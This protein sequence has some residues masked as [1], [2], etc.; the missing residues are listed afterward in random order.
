MAA[1]IADFDLACAAAAL[2]V[3]PVKACAA[4]PVQALVLDARGAAAGD[5][6]WAIVNADG[7]VT[8]QGEFPR[9]ALVHPRVA[10]AGLLLAS[11]GAGEVAT[12]A[13]LADCEVK[14]WSD[15]KARHETFEAADAGDAVAAWLARVVG[16]PARLVRLGEA[17]IAREGNNALH[18]VFAPSVRAVDAQLAAAGRPGADPRRYRPNIVLSGLAGEDGVEF[19][20]ESLAALDWQGEGEAVRLEITAPC[21]RCPVPNV[22]PDSG[23]V[24]DTVG[25]TLA[26]MSRQRRGEGGTVFGVYA[27]GPA[28]AR[29]RVGDRARMSLAF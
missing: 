10:G 7:A 29:L 6:G 5:R 26:R 4:M 18:L 3:Y 20:E 22:D 8:W 15:A 12:P 28:G 16:A 19:V 13:G 27:R 17:A 25:D 14:I 24:D 1:S 2:Y 11:P 23:L 21:V 9:L